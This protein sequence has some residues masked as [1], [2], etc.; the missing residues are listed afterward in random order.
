MLTCWGVKFEDPAMLQD[1]PNLWWFDWR[2]GRHP[3]LDWIGDLKHL[4]YLQIWHAYGV[5]SV[6]FL[7]SLTKLQGLM[8]YALPKVQS[9]PNLGG[10]TQLRT[11][12]LGSMKSLVDIHGL[13]SAPA[14]ESLGLGD[15]VTL[16]S[17]VADQFKGHPALSQFGWQ[18]ERPPPHAKLVT[19]TLGLGKYKT[20]HREQWPFENLSELQEATLQMCRDRIHRREKR[21]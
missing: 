7:T 17:A 12:E 5:E 4:I 21:L 3:S 11:V 6:D 16:S 18:G 19:D 20:M 15:K 9:I 13:A 8:L 10:L 1:L 14:L 2:G